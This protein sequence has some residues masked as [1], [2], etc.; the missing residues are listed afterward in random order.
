MMYNKQGDNMLEDFKK[1]KDER[2]V[3]FVEKLT[4]CKTPSLGIKIPIIKTYLQSISPS[5]EL[6]DTIPLNE[7]I[8][9]DILYG[10]I[11]IKLGKR[12]DETYNQYLQL[13]LDHINNWMTC[14]TFVS[15]TKYKESELD[16]LYQLVKQLIQTRDC[17]KVR[18]GL[19]FLKR[20]FLKQKNF[21]EIFHLISTI[22]YG[23]YYVDMGCAWLLCTMACMEYEWF[24]KNID[25]IKSLSPFILKKTIQKMRDSYLITKEQKELL[26]KINSN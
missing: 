20:Y 12:K 4:P 7:Y 11:L 15:N 8:E 21:D 16:D 22:E 3:A 26:S 2:Q 9:I 23:E 18:V 25:K 24:S 10:L 5:Y 17:F 1:L 6:L 19:V 13:Y 14:D